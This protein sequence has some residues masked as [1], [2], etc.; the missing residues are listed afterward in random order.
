MRQRPDARAA[1]NCGDG[2]VERAID[3]AGKPWRTALRSGLRLTVGAARCTRIGGSRANERSAA[4]RYCRVVRRRAPGALVFEHGHAPDSQWHVQTSKDPVSA[5]THESTPIVHEP[6]PMQATPFGT[7]EGR[8]PSEGSGVSAGHAPAFDPLPPG[9]ATRT[10]DQ[11]GGNH[12][13]FHAPHDGY[14]PNEVPSRAL[15]SSLT[16]ASTMRSTSATSPLPTWPSATSP[17][18]PCGGDPD[19]AWRERR[20]PTWKR[21]RLC[22]PSSP[23][24]PWRCNGSC[25]RTCP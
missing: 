12:E 22:R 11:S 9:V 7:A 10:A 15:N 13:P 5:P 16:F 20:P 6:V 18:L 4:I 23:Q 2:R 3:I 1:A 17:T 25:G 14:T 8:Y 24:R 21:R 19:R